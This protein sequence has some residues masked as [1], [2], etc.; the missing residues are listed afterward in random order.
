MRAL[1]F[2]TRSGSDLVTLKFTK[3]LPL[4]VLYLTLTICFL[5][6]IIFAQAPYQRIRDAAA[7]P[8]NWLT[9]SGNYQSHRFSPLK[10]I[11]RTNVA[12][13]KTAWVYQMRDPGKVEATPLVVDGIIYLAEKPH[14]VTA[15]NGATGIPLWTY[16]R[17]TPADIRAC[18]G[19]PNRGLAILDDTL[20]L[21]TFDAHLVA[22]EAKTGKVK[23]DVV[24]A[25]YKTGYS[26]TGAPLAIKGKI[27]VGVAGGEF[28]IR[29]F[30]DAYSP[31]DGKR[32]WRFWTVPATGEKGNETWAGDSWKTGGAPTWLTGSYDPSLNLIYWGTGNPAPDWN[33]DS[34]AGDNLY[35]DSL[36]ALDADT[37]T[38]KWHFQFTPHDT[39]DWDANQIPILVDEFIDGRPR[40]LVVTANRNG[41]YYVLDRIT[42]KFLRGASYIKQTW[43]KGLDTDGRPLVLPNIDP[44]PEGTLLY[45]SFWGGTNW[46]SPS[47][48][49]N[50][51]LFYVL[52]ADNDPQYFLKE[53]TVYH[54]GELFMG[55][56]G[57]NVPGVIGYGVVKA[58]DV[59][60]GQQK[61]EYKLPTRV[62]A[63]VMATAGGLVF[64]GSREGYFYALDATTG[65]Q[66][67][68]FMA[69][70]QIVSNPISY[71]I[72]GKQY[73]AISSGNG[74]FVFAL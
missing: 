42:G 24:V 11:N 67:W 57:R 36:L 47:Y 17:T 32:L 41:F 27:I 2:S 13:L 21:C 4:L 58:L 63:G 43:A 68:N 18:C 7:E 72:R 6:K 49:P 52:A 61:W 62:M 44:T 30:L 35:S 59:K 56:G 23:W 38:L 22:L 55:G 15:L 26:M 46:N 31:K 66:L 65:K 39:H 60:T 33:G 37:G 51:K 40:K 48:S 28:G 69:G 70:A 1:F 53:D 73:V 25:D 14:V 8:Q 64:G 29:G 54:A 10:Q 71:A 9:Y 19:T 74:L 16:R 20:Y 50:T 5:A 45:P 12:R 3:S 34:R